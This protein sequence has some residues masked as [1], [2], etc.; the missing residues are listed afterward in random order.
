MES[1][2][3][4]E[5][6]EKAERGFTLAELAIATAVLMFGVVAVMRLVPLATST[7]TTNRNDTTAMVIAQHFLDE[8]TAQ[9]LKNPTVTDPVCGAMSLGAGVAGALP[10]MFPAAGY[11]INL[12]GNAT[13]DFT[14]AAV[15][16][17]S[18][19]YSDPNDVYSGNYQV[20]WG[21]VVSVNGAG[22]VQWKRFVVGVKGRSPQFRFPVNVGATVQ[23]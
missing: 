15:A 3:G 4:K 5:N 14:Q 22:Q 23:R 9:P 20:R 6:R 12:N 18:C 19:N 1:M 2:A 7:D 16:G 13:V 10:T 8:L 11:L 21:V 17:Y